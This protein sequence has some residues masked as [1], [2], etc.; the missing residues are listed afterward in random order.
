VPRI[1]Q[2]TDLHL[3]ARAGARCRGVDTWDS[4]DRVLGA[5]HAH[6]PD[7]VIA[8]GDLADDPR[9]P[10]YR[11]LHERLG[12]G[13]RVH[14]L[15]GNHDRC[16]LVR[17]IFSS[18]TGRF[19]ETVGTWRLLGLDTSTPRRVHGLIGSKQLEWLAAELADG[20]R[21]VLL[22]MHHPPLRI[23]CWWLDKDL[24][25][26]VDALERV[27]GGSHR[28]RAIFTGHVHQEFLGRFAGVPVHTTPSTAYQFLPRTW[29]P[30]R[31]DALTPGYRLIELDGDGWS[32][33]V[34]RLGLGSEVRKAAVGS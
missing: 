20:D 16:E 13:P 28:V 11:Q 31:L 25:R 34:H 3:R 4:L 9:E 26:D 29:V 32:S 14:V 30:A 17:S 1:V 7:L 6:E 23:G 12:R 2:I 10:T 19:A 8:T 5:V 21:P 22:F 24:I 15:P 18:E 27:I 33:R